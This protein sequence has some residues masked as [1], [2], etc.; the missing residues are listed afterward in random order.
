MNTAFNFTEIGLN[1]RDKRVYETLLIMPQASLRKIADETGINRGSVYES[2]KQ[3]TAV[4]LVGSLQK[5]QRQQFVAQNPE[6]I[7]E[8]LRERQRTAKEA[9]K[10]AGEYIQNLHAQHQPEQTHSFVLYYEG[11]EGVAAILRDV[12]KTM[13]ESSDKHYYALSSK[14]IRQ[15]I[16]NNFPN[17]TQ[18]RVE[19]EIE[20]SVIA[21]GEGGEADPLSN[22][23]WLSDPGASSNCY[24]I[25]YGT[26]TAFI[27]IDDQN[28]LSGTVIDNEG[29]TNLQKLQFNE[30]WN[31]LCTPKNS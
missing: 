15:Y 29:V 9:E 26:K 1:T 7:I 31:A 30:V 4:G 3:L 14:R 8:L 28:I 13:R 12:L 24:T 23:V 27:S 11:D 19:N 18:Q 21:V 20:V 16:Y 10:T 5:G 25:I 22:R 17:Y 6:L 2:I